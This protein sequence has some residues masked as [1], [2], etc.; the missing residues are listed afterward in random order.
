MKPNKKEAE[1]QPKPAK[2]PKPKKVGRPSLG[3]DARNVPLT[4]KISQNEKQRWAKQAKVLGMG[5]HEY[6]LH[7]LRKPNTEG[8]E[9]ERV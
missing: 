1:N 9:N 4:I 7:P 2:K 5:L 3:R 8:S 6:I